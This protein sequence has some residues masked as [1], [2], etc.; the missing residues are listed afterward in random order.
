[1]SNCPQIL[2]GVRRIEIL[3]FPDVQLLDVAGVLQVF[4][5]ANDAMGAPWPYDARVVANVC[6]ITTS[7]GLPICCDPLSEVNKPLDTLIVAGGRGVHKAADNKALVQWV[8]GRASIA[9]RVASVCSGAFLLGAAGLLD[10]KRAVTHWNDCADLA[11]LYQTATIEVDPIFIQ[12]GD[13]WTS[14]GVTAGIDLAL[15]MVGSDIGQAS[16]IAIARDLVVFLKRPGGQAQFSAALDLQSRNPDFEELHAWIASHL[17]CK[18]SNSVLADRMNM[19][20]RNF[21]RR[22]STTMGLSPAKA[23]EII[24]LDSA[25]NILLTTDT[26]LK[27]VAQWCGFGSEES[28]RRA[29]K[30]HL[31]TSPIEYRRRFTL[32]TKS[33]STSSTRQNLPK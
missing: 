29:F 4:S 8:A 2:P 23:V 32:P 27:R 11:R 15:A 7:S 5:S 31:G 16:A 9:R 6:S 26:P 10:G 21:I 12:D 30:R 25:K 1:M 17:D 3:A 18:L 33:T 22:Y 28:I 20:E 14:A 13:L 24:R 19:S